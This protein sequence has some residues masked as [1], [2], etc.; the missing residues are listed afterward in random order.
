MKQ[1]L[2]TCRMILDD[3]SWQ[4]NR[5]GIRSIS[6]P[7]VSMRFNLA[8]G[9]PAVTTKKL[10]F[11]SILGELC[12]FMR[13]TR[14]AAEFR[15]LG[16]KVW[17]DNAN[18]P[19]K[20]GSPNAWLS[21]PFRVG[22]DALGEIYGAMWREWPAYKVISYQQFIHPTL[23]NKLYA[24]GWKLVSGLGCDEDDGVFNEYLY[25]KEI[26]MLGDCIRKIIKTPTDRRILFHAWNPAK[27]DEM[28]LPPCHLLYQFLPNVSTG[29]L[30]MCLYIRSNDMFLGSPFNIAE[31]ALLLEL[32]ARLTG[33]KAKWFTYFVGD[34]H[35]YENSLDQVKEQLTREPHHLPR[36]VIDEAVPT[37]ERFVL[38]TSRL[39]AESK[40]LIN[41]R[42]VAAE[43]A[44]DW[45][46]KVEPYHFSLQGY[47]HHAAIKAEMAV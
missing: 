32:V 41:V 1:Y 15:E 40:E 27:L 36:L 2:D 42:D 12:G 45:L 11:K 34:A 9:F 23:T 5:T 39:A 4:D 13:A 30:S 25:H 43:R 26:D 7:G 3:G 47:E 46:K 14:S 18:H 37:Y 38:A 22:E 24:E 35:I 20:E 44:V 21:N 19:G 10:A 6:V 17:D 8:K 33:Y 29:E 31:G 28:A 16:C